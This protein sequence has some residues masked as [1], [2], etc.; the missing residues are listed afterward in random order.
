MVWRIE[1]GE[2]IEWNGMGR[3]VFPNGGKKY[4]LGFESLQSCNGRGSWVT[5]YT[6][7]IFVTSTAKDLKIILNFPYQHVWHVNCQ[8]VICY[9]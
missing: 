7:V 9:I 4:L 1:K 5:K 8:R 3:M 2:K 6:S